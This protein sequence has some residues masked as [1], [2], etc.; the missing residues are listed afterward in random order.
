M[1]SP[2]R[3]PGRVCVHVDQSLNRRAAQVH[4]R[5]TRPPL[6]SKARPALNE[7]DLPTILPAGRSVLM[8]RRVSA[9]E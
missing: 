4:I 5:Q 8:T 7:D 6:T 2:Y 1:K 3:T 9:T